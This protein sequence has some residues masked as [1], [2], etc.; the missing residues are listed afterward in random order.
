MSESSVPRT[1]IDIPT[2]QPDSALPHGVFHHV[3]AGLGVA[4]ARPRVLI[5]L[6]LLLLLSALPVFLPVFHSLDTVLSPLVEASAL[7]RQLPGW[8]VA[9]WRRAAP[10]V[11]ATAQEA[12]RS[13]LLLSSLLGLFIGA[14][15]MYVATTDRRRTGLRGFCAGGGAFFFPFLR[16]WL[17]WLGL[18]WALGH[19]FYGPPA[20]WLAGRFFLDGDPELAASESA[21]RTFGL[22][23]QAS[24]LVALFLLEVSI[25]YGRASLVVGSRHSALLGLA[26]GF[27]FLLMEPRRCLGVV[28]VG[29]LLEAGWIAGA[30]WLLTDIGSGAPDLSAVLISQLLIF[31]RIAL[32]GGR[33]AAVASVYA[34]ARRGRVALRTAA[35]LARLGEPSPFDDGTAWRARES[36]S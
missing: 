33:L 13:M 21:A 8:L 22:A 18:A 4:L 7:D 9:D 32:R 12:L 28:L 15:W 16:S 36:S 23:Q 24:Y 17:L 5:F 30:A 3:F 31:G 20:E 27:L 19:L 29:F 34:E 6:Y 25:D 35:A 2:T 1:P 11:E 10:G 26:R 14:G